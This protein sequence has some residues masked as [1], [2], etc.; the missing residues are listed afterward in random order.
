MGT[1]NCLDF[2]PY[3]VLVH[4]TNRNFIYIY[5]YFKIF[6]QVNVVLLF[7]NK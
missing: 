6:S 3:F 1:K 2:R 4:E 7:F 5:I